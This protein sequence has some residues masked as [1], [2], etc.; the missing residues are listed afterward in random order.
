MNNKKAQWKS[1]L[2]PNNI[3]VATFIGAPSMNML[4][5]KLFPDFVE[6]EGKRIFLKKRISE[7]H[8]PIPRDGKEIK[9]GIRP[10]FFHDEEFIDTESSLSRIRNVKVD[11]IE[12]LGF[13]K[14]LDVKLGSQ[15]FKA[16]LDLRT[17]A[18]EGETLNLCFNMDRAHF[19]DTE[20]EKNLFINQA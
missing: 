17:S 18:K 5:A 11:L 7:G 8:I 14:E 13:D 2:I 20:T 1:I 4:K 9:L 10:D 19:F 12:P 3:F 16:R 6:L 15:S